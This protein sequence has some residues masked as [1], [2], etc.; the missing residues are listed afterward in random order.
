MGRAAVLCTWKKGF[1]SHLSPP[2]RLKACAC[3]CVRL[4]LCVRVCMCSLH[5][6]HYNSP[7]ERRRNKPN[8]HTRGYIWYD[9]LSIRLLFHRLEFL[10]R[11]HWGQECESCFLRGRDRMAQIRANVNGLLHWDKAICT[12]TV[13]KPV[14]SLK[15]EGWRC[16]AEPWSGS[17][18]TCNDTL[19][20]DSTTQ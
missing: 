20:V 17:V 4:R 6:S 7:Q 19:S 18:G 2:L 13:T 16:L 9:R 12:T 11:P 8:S 1:L 3:A 14:E 10:R 15:E 5:A